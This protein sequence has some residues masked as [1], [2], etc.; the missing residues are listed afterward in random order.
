MY[1]D[2]SD[3]FDRLFGTYSG[4]A[5]EHTSKDETFYF[6]DLDEPIQEAIIEL[7]VSIIKNS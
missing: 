2:E 5:P 4:P 3:L 1:E 7:M 6:E